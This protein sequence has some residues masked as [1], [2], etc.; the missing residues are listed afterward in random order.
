MYGHYLKHIVRC[1]C[2][3]LAFSLFTCP[4]V[5]AKD[6]GLTEDQVINFG[7]EAVSLFQCSYFAEK[8]EDQ[9]AQIKYFTMGYERIIQYFDYVRSGKFSK[10]IRS[11]SPLILLLNITGPSSEFCAGAVWSQISSDSFRRYNI[12]DYSGEGLK[13]HA[14]NLLRKKNAIFLNKW[15]IDM[16]IS[17]ETEGQLKK[18]DNELLDTYYHHHGSRNGEQAIEL[19]RYRQVERSVQASERLGTKVFWLN[20]IL[21]AATVVMALVAVISFVKSGSPATSM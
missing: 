14:E 16:G 20:V 15:G 8:A 3:L 13:L 7:N 12:G 18:N 6:K 5:F 10:K 9:E 1:F 17:Q 21:T 19:L 4:L 11:K 2:L